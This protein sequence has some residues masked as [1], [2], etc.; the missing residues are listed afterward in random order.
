NPVAQDPV[1]DEDDEKVTGKQTADLELT[2]EADKQEV[3]RA[4][5]EITYTLTVTNT[6]NVTLTDVTVNDEML[7]GNLDVSP[8]TLAPGE[9]GTVTGTYTVT[10]KDIDRVDEI[11]N[12]A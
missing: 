12:I 3:E 8:S 9:Q 10:Q 5:E 6:G 4:G 2:K 11:V 7:G 1:T